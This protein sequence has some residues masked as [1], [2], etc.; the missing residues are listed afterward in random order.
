MESVWDLCGGG[1]GPIFGV[2]LGGV[3]LGRFPFCEFFLG[4]GIPFGVCVGDSI[5][6]SFLGS[7]PFLG[8]VFWGWIPFGVISRSWLGPFVGSHFFVGSL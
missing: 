7:I 5:L 6:G 3:P 2:F 8:A 4:W 1:G